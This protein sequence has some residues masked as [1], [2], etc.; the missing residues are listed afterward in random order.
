MYLCRR[1]SFS[2]I[3]ILY[4]ICVCVT[5]VSHYS[6]W[7]YWSYWSYWITSSLRL[8]IAHFFKTIHFSGHICICVKIHF[9]PPYPSVKIADLTWKSSPF[10]S[11]S[12]VKCDI[13][14]FIVQFMVSNWNGFSYLGQ[15]SDIRAFFSGLGGILILKFW[16]RAGTKCNFSHS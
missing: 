1:T 12:L 4:R 16:A 2:H 6:D 8:Q 14:P 11:E 13:S 3:C 7:W 15:T 9:K 5:W 10:W